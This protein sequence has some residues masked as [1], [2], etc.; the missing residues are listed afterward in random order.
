M[1]GLYMRLTK[2]FHKSKSESTPKTGKAYQD[3]RRNQLGQAMTEY[4]F[5]V[6]VVGLVCIPVFKWLPDAIRG[7]V[8]PFYYVVSRPIP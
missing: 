1:T 8:R 5:L 6:V 3:I 2:C 4:V 7:Y